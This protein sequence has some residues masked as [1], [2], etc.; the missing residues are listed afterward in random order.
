[1]FCIPFHLRGVL[2]IKVVPPTPT[3]P[4]LLIHPSYT[5]ETMP[6]YTLT[7]YYDLA[8]RAPLTECVPYLPQLCPHS[9]QPFLPPR[10]SGCKLCGRQLLAC[11]IWFSWSAAL[12]AKLG[13]PVV[14]PTTCTGE[15]RSIYYT[16]GIPL[17]ELDHSYV[18]GDIVKSIIISRVL[19]KEETITSL[20]KTVIYSTQ[21]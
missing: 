18:D 12:M 21:C 2:T 19:F 4:R 20:V 17:G 5:D 6:A 7:S 14:L 11:Y 8:C 10:T 9:L 13:A 3:T 1:L 15:V 16:L